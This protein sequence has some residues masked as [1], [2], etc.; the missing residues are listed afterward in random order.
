LEV[1]LLISELRGNILLVKELPWNGGRT[2]SPDTTVPP[3]LCFI[4]EKDVAEMKSFSQTRNDE[5]TLSVV[6]GQWSVVS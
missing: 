3:E 4:N 1:E 5:Q 2:Y 6:S